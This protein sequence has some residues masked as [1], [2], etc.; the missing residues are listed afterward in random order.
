MKMTGLWR[1]SAWLLCLYSILSNIQN[2]K[3]QDEPE[4]SAESGQDCQIAEQCGLPASSCQT[5][6]SLYTTGS[7]VAYVP[8]IEPST[9]ICDL[10]TNAKTPYRAA[11]WFPW[12]SQRSTRA[13]RVSLHLNVLSCRNDDDDDQSSCCCRPMPSGTVEIW[14]TYPNGRYPSLDSTDCRASQSFS[15]TTTTDTLHF[16]TLAPGSTGALGG[17]GP[18]GWDFAPYGPPVF[19]ILIRDADH[20]VVQL[21]DVPLLLQVTPSLT[22]SAFRGPD[23]RGAAWIRGWPREPYTISYEMVSAQQIQLT[24]DLYVTAPQSLQRRMCSTVYGFPASFFL[25]PVA[26]CAAPMRQFFP[27]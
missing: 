1:A 16:E 22:P 5:H 15:D 9:T 26:V 25:E 8:N 14:Q 18:A 20:S 21:V 17:L 4:C 7:A 6:S 11:G 2:V 3:A 23:L 12:R 19:H 13:P 27:L 10:F 24:V